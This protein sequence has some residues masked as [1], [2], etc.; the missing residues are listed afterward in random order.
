[1]LETLRA[2]GAGLLARAGEQDVAAVALAGYALQVAEEA[3]GLQTGTGELAAARWLDA[4]EATM[5][6][7]LAWAMEH[8]PAIAL[9]LAVA[10]APWWLLR[11]RLAAR[12]R[13]CARLPGRPRWAATGGARSGSGS[14]GWRCT[15][16]I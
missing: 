3:A 15:Q 4:E 6:Q 10:L 12:T 7:V 9:R 8:D 2:Y 14:A 5:R 1:M 16:P 13:C 11:G